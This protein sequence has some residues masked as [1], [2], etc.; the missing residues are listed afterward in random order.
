MLRKGHLYT[1]LY[2]YNVIE[3]HF[4]VYTC[5][6]RTRSAGLVNVAPFHC[7]VHRERGER[8]ERDG[9]RER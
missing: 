5:I 1:A 8:E 3:L 6:W 4:L 2:N 9:G 7:R